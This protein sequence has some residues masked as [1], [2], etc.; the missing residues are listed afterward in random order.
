M[1]PFGN[2]TTRKA[3]SFARVIR[4]KYDAAITHADNVRH[5]ANADSLSADAAASPD[6]RQT[7]RNRSRYEVANNSY[8]RGIVL[9]LANDCVGTGP[10]LQL[11]SDDTET[12]DLIETAFAEWASEI[13]LP[14]KL[15]LMRMAKA[16]DGEVFGMLTANPVLR[17]PI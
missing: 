14:A 11:I 16:V 13:H 9:T 17:S 7:L 2:K 12:N 15:R 10:R 3:R 5:W 6:V 1:W 8:A 4:A